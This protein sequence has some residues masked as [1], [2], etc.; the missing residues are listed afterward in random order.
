MLGPLLLFIGLLLF[1]FGG[2]LLLVWLEK[3]EVRK[4]VD[5]AINRGIK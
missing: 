5:K 2:L 3:R 4:I 1:S